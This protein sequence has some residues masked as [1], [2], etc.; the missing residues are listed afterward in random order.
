MLYYFFSIRQADNAY[1]FDGLE[2]SKDKEAMQ[3]QNQYPVIFMSLKDLKD[4][5]FQDQLNNFQI[6]LSEIIS[7]NEELLISEHLDEMDRDLLKRY[8]AGTVNK[9][10]L[11]NGLRFLSNCLEKHWKKKVVLLIDE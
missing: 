7:R 4:L 1:L 11:Q 3:Y 9:A 5:S 8:K 10:Q 6:I 2:I